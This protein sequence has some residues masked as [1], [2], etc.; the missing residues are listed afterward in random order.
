[1]TREDGRAFV[2]ALLRAPDDTAKRV[3]A[4]SLLVCIRRQG[5]QAARKQ[6]RDVGVRTPR[7]LVRD[8]TP[9]QREALALLLTGRPVPPLPRSRRRAIEVVHVTSNTR[10]ITRHVVTPSHTEQVRQLRHMHALGLRPAT[11]AAVSSIVWDVQR[12][13]DEVDRLIRDD[14]SEAA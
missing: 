10:T 13:A 12:R 4:D 11:L 1:M 7:P 5:P 8:L 3:P 6:L 14:E 9:G 2:A